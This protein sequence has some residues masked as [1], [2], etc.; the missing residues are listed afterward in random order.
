VSVLRSDAGGWSSGHKLFSA[1]CH[2][3]ADAREQ[4]LIDRCFVGSELA[5]QFDGRN[6]VVT[7]HAPH[8][9]SIEDRCKSDLTSPA[10]ANYLPNIMEQRL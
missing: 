9:Y 4:N 3:L 10:F 6:I 1:A 2:G 7:R 5:K 8:P